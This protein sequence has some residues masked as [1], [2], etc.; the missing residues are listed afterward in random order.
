MNNLDICFEVIDYILD[1]GFRKL[2]IK[3]D[4]NSISFTIKNIKHFEFFIEIDE[5]SEE[6]YI[7]IY[8]KDLR[9]KNYN[10]NYYNAYLKTWLTKDEWNDRKR[11]KTPFIYFKFMCQFIK[12]H[13]IMCYLECINHEGYYIKDRLLPQYIKERYI[14]NIK[15]WLVNIYNHVLYNYT[16]C[17]CAIAKHNNIIDDIIIKD[18]KNDKVIRSFPRWIVTIIFKDG[19]KIEDE[20]KFLNFWFRKEDYGLYDGKI[21][22]EYRQTL[23][24]SYYY[25]NERW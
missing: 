7:K 20:L 6:K 12:R 17:K 25:D 19:T 8:A 10:V 9:K 16:K 23:S 5:N 15:Y 14:N 22:K 2:N 24:H 4:D 18:E 1:M 11:M 21:E 13:P 3:T